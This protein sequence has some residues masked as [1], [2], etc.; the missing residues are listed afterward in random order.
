M[1][2]SQFNSVVSSLIGIHY[3]EEKV[4]ILIS[5]KSC[6]N[7]AL[8]PWVTYLRMIVYKG[9]V[10]HSSPNFERSAVSLILYIEK[11][12]LIML[13]KLTGLNFSLKHVTSGGRGHF[14]PPVA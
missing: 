14:W 10:K 6:K 5:Q 2:S 11:F 12:P 1:L 8:R 3:E 7:R 9:I 4:W 13:T